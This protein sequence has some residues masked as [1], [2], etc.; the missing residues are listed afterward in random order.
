MIL[1]VAPEGPFAVELVAEGVS[2]EI[3]HEAVALDAL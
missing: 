1:F 3:L 2:L